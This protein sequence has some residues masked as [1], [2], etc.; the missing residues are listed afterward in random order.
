ML[1]EGGASGPRGA[2][3]FPP[4]SVPAAPQTPHSFRNRLY[5]NKV[6]AARAGAEASFDAAQGALGR[7]ANK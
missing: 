5:K 7:G 6:S 2:Q 1:P 4:P 3:V